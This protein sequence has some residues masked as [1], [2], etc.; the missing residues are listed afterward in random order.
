M[1]NSQGPMEPQC[2]FEDI[3]GTIFNDQA[4]PDEGPKQDSWGLE[5]HLETKFAYD[6]VSLDWGLRVLQTIDDDTRFEFFVKSVQ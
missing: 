5:L 3:T 2:L 4:I 6:N 1:Q